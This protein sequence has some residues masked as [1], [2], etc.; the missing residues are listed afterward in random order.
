MENQS[1]ISPSIP[2]APTSPVPTQKNP[3]PENP[4]PENPTPAI[5]TSGTSTPDTPNPE[6]PA[7]KAPTIQDLQNSRQKPKK[8]PKLPK[9][10]S[11]NKKSKKPLVIVL[12]VLFSLALIAGG[13]FYYFK[14][15][16]KSPEIVKNDVEFLTEVDAWE[17]SGAP[18]VIWSFKP[19]GTGELTTNKEN[20]YSLKWYLSDGKLEIDTSW[21]YELSDSFE[22]TLDRASEIPSFTV[23]NLADETVSTFVPLGESE[24]T[25]DLTQVEEAVE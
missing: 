20:Y 2:P 23:K 17:K 18:T 10:K 9:T 21:L 13:I 24:R 4:I 12:V 5:S 1:P 6:A 8:S 16:R 11:L 14:F 19:D 22:I 25:S 3:T 7:P 15:L